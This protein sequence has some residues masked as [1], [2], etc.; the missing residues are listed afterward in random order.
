MTKHVSLALQA[1]DLRFCLETPDLIR[2]LRAAVDGGFV[3]P[4]PNAW[5][6]SL[7]PDLLDTRETQHD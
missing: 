6:D 3:P 5:W 7:P 2:C 4:L 1:G